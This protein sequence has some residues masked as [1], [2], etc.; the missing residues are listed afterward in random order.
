M[1]NEQFGLSEYNPS[2]KQT[3]CLPWTLTR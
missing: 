1:N 3:N 2:T